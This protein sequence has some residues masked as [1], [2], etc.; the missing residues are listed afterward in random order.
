MGKQ[1]VEEKVKNK[2]EW[3]KKYYPQ[4]NPTAFSIPSLPY[5]HHTIG[6]VKNE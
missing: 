3:L 1:S 5:C 2:I 4:E 6:C